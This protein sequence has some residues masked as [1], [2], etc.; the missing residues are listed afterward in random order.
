MWQS[1]STLPALTIVGDQSIGVDETTIEFPMLDNRPINPISS[2]RTRVHLSD[3]AKTP[4][5]SAVV[6]EVLSILDTKD[7]QP[8][9]CKKLSS[10]LAAKFGVA[11]P[12]PLTRKNSA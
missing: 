6:H 5:E 12:F 3:Y 8:A 10:T 4:I 9:A 7:S 2:V 11:I 1:A